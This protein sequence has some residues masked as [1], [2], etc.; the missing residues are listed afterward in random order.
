MSQFK[1]VLDGKINIVESL[2]VRLMKLEALT[3]NRNVI[4]DLFLYYLRKGDLK[5]A[6]YWEVLYRSK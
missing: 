6:S 3:G 1:L 2:E 5:E 4:A